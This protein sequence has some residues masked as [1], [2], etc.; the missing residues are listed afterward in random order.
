MLILWTKSGHYH[1]EVESWH[2]RAIVSLRIVGNTS[3]TL[4]FLLKCP[5]THTR[6]KETARQFSIVTFE[7]ILQCNSRLLQNPMKNALYIT[8]RASIFF[9]GGCPHRPLELTP[10]TFAKLAL[11]LTKAWLRS[12]RACVWSEWKVPGPWR[13][14]QWITLITSMIITNRIMTLR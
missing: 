4:P 10:L 2:Q 1:R 8:F 12:V 14:L 5:Q 7:E 13:I 6:R 3:D 11:S 9:E